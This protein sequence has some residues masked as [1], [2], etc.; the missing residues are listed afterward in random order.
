M[1]DYYKTLG[2]SK[3]ASKED[4]KKAYRKLAHKHHPDKGGDEKTFKKISE[5]YQ[6]LSDD[7]KRTQYDNFGRSGPGMGGAGAQSSSTGDGFGGFSSADFDFGDIFE[8]FFGFGGANRGGRT[9]KGPRKG[10]DVKIRIDTTL[11]RAIKNEE[12]K[13]KLTRFVACSSCQGSGD[14]PGAKKEKCKTCGG[15]GSVITSIG[16]FRQK[17]MCPNCEGSGE[18]SDKKCSSCKGEGRVQKTEEIA[19]T[20][21]AGISSGQTLRVEGKG[22]AGI[23]GGPTGDLL[24]DIFVENDTKFERDGSDLYCTVEVNYTKLVLGGKIDVKTIF[25]SNISV[26]IPTGTS[27]ETVLRISNKGLPKLSGYSNGNL[28]L[29]LKVSVP[30]KTTKKQKKLLEELQEDGI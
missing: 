12:R 4:I 2:V 23:K 29:R 24:V 18:V 19:F 13:I 21:P 28:Y 30:K 8:E 25:G 17:S 27:P 20:I 6:V 3:D 22:N 16:P 9:R 1:E 10:E 14:A 5:A 11:S 7:K 15:Q 26:K